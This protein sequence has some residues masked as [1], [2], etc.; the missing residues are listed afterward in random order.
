LQS[1]NNENALNP[2]KLVQMMSHMILSGGKSFDYI[3][4]SSA[5]TGRLARFAGKLALCVIRAF[6]QQVIFVFSFNINSERSGKDNEHGKIRATMF[7]LSF[8]LL[9][10]IRCLYPDLVSRK[11]V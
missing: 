2:Q 3:C 10:R 5:A 4:A 8:L 11:F 9:S 6:L 7:D 1:F